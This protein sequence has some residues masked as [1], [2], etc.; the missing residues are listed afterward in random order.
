MPNDFMFK[1]VNAVHRFVVRTTKG[2]VGGSGLGMPVLE[3]T[4]IGRKSG[5][6][7]TVMLTAPVQD[8]DS[9]VIVASKGGDDRN[10]AWFLNLQANPD[11]EVAVK[12]G[13][14]T[15]MRA[16]V[17]EGDE[18]AA[19]WER[20]VK[21]HTNYAGYQRKTTREIPLVSLEPR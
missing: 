2:K 9:L 8:G 12:G 19:L 14:T 13:P 16:R 20:V 7:R 18:R 1:A 3:L 17:V 6:K 11:V 15:P 4:T 21:D 5:E 10:P